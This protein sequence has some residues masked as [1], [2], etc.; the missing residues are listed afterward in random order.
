MRNICLV[1]E[2][3]RE[4][5]AAIYPLISREREHSGIG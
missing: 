1:E 5:L 4:S 3:T 2:P